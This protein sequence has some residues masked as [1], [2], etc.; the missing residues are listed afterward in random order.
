MA[1]PNKDVMLCAGPA[2]VQREE[3][4]EEEED[5][6]SS[7]ALEHSVSN[8][9]PTSAASLQPRSHSEDRGAADNDQVLLLFLKK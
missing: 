5:G 1:F 7:E 9:S 2:D 3:E 4:E 8:Q 6:S